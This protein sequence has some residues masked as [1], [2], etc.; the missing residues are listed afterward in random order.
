[1]GNHYHLLIQTPEPNLVVGMKWLQNTYTR[2]FN[3]RHRLS[4]VAGGCAMLPARRPPGLATEDTPG[5]F[6]C[7]DTAAGRRKWVERL[8]RRASQEARKSCGVPDPPPEADGRASH[9]RRG[10]YWGSQ[11]FAE[12]MLA[13]AA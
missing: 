2:R 10:Y 12:R 13:L 4:S 9:F 6:G 8:D 3:I 1:M 5:A 11:A 7:A